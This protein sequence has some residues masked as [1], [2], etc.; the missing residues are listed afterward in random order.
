[1]LLHSKISNIRVVVVD[2]IIIIHGICRMF[3]C[4]CVINRFNQKLTKMTKGGFV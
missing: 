1:M 3:V 4:V 2:S